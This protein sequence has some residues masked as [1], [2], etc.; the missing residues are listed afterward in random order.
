MVFSGDVSL[1]RKTIQIYTSRL[2]T[3]LLR[4]IKITIIELR[5]QKLALV[6]VPTRNYIPNMIYAIYM[7][8]VYLKCYVCNHTYGQARLDKMERATEVSCDEYMC[9]IKGKRIC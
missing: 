1:L 5:V 6:W 9:G 2:L 3:S 4:I 8:C 7:I